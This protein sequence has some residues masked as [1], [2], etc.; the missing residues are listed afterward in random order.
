MALVLATAA[1]TGPSGVAWSAPP[2]DLPGTGS[3]GDPFRLSA[4]EDLE[5]LAAQLGA[6]NATYTGDRHYV[7]TADLDFSTRPPFPGIDQFGGT[8]DGRGHAI[9]N[10]VFTQSAT[11]S[12]DGVRGRLGLIR[13]ADGAT[14]ANLALASPVATSSSNV[15]GHYVAGIV[16]VAYNTDFRG[17][18]IQGAS[19][20][21]PGVEKVGGIVAELRG[22]TVRDSFVSGTL[23]GKKM[24][25]GIA[26]YA[27]QGNVPAV[28]ERTVVDADLTVIVNGGERGVDAAM[29]VNYPGNPSSGSLFQHNVALGGTITYAG[30]REGFAG[31]IVGYTGYD[32]WTARDNLAAS[33]ITIG[34]QTVTGPGA[35]GEQG[36]D[37][38]PEALAQQATYEALNWDF[39]EKWAWDALA[40]H[41]VPAYVYSLFG[42]GTGEDPYQ[43]ASEYDLEFLAAELAAGNTKYTGAKSFAMT[44]DLDFAGREP[45]GGIDTFTG[46]LDGRGHSISGLVYT[47]SP[48][49]TDATK[50]GRLALI[51][52]TTGATISNLT[53]QAP[54]AVNAST[55]EGHFTAGIVAVAYRTTFSRIAVIDALF[56][57]PGAEKAAGIVAEL[58]GGTISDCF[59]SGTIVGKKLVAA[60]AAYAIQADGV[61]ARIERTLTDADLTVVSDG[62]VNGSRGI[63][64]AMVLSYPGNP[65]AGNT[66]TGNVAL[67]GSI[68]Y[69]GKV[70]GFTGR[71]IGYTDYAGWTVQNNL[72]NSAITISGAPVTGPGTKDQHGADT[73]PAALGLQAT[74]ESIGWV[75]GEQWR[76]DADLGHPMPYIVQ[77][78]ERPSRIATTIH[79]DTTSRRGFSWYSAHVSDTAAVQV[80][81]VRD[82]N[83]PQAFPA[84]RS[85]GPSGEPRYQAVATGLVPGTRYYY[86]VGFPALGLWSPTGS[87]QTA[88]GVSPFAFIDLTDTQSQSLSEAEL[89]ATTMAKALKH[90]PQAEF[91]LHQ[92]DVVEHGALEQD[93]I[94]LLDSAQ[95]TLLSTT[96]APA[97]GNHDEAAGAFIGH[98][99]LEAPNGQNTST[100]A[101]YSFDYN[102]AHIAVLNTN[103]GGAQG[104]SASQLQWLEGDVTAARAAG[105]EWVFL[106]MH[107]GLYTTATHVG[108][109]DVKAMR[110][111]VAPLI[112]RLDIDLVFQGHDHIMARSKVLNYDASGVAGAK[113]AETATITEVKNGKRIEYAIDPT[114]TIYFLPNAAGAKHYSQASGAPGGVDMEAYLE[115]FDRS[116]R[117]DQ[118]NFAA[119]TVEP[120]RVTVNCYDIR[121]QGS[122]RIFEGFGI[123]RQVGAVD[124]ALAALPAAD[125]VTPADAD[126]LTQAR[127]AVDGLTSAQRGGLEHLRRLESAER[128]WR[129]A[130]GLVAGDGSE[131]AWAYQGATGRRTVNLRN[132]TRTAFTDVP[133]RL[134]LPTT[135]QVDA[136][137]LRVFTADGVPVTHEVETWNRGGVSVVWV[138]APALP[139]RSVTTLWVYYGGDANT[140]NNPTAVWAEDYALVEHFATGG[141]PGGLVADS[142]GHATG[143][144]T[145]AALTATPS[146]DGSAGA[147]FTGSKLTYGGDLGGDFDRIAISA[148]VAVDENDLAAMSANSPYVAKESRDHGQ[149]TFWQGIAKAD[150]KLG[151]R[152]ATSSWEHSAT[153]AS[154]RFDLPLDGKSHL[155]T[156][157]Y[158]GMTYS[159]FID[160]RERHSQMVEYG[161][162][163][164][165]PSVRTTIGDY[166]TADGALASPF[167]GRIEEIQIAGVKV[168]PDFEAF[169][170]DSYFGDAVTYDPVVTKAGEPLTLIVGTP[171][172]GTEVE[173]GLVEVAGTLNRAG[174]LTATMAGD[175]VYSGEVQAGRFTAIVPVNLLGDQ[176][177]TLAV[178]SAGASAQVAVPLTVVDTVAPA[179][180]ALTVT[181]TDGGGMALS[182]TPDTQDREP[183]AVRFYATPALELGPDNLAVG[184]GSTAAR[185]PAGLTPGSGTLSDSGLPTTVGEGSN[186][187]Q[188]YRIAL[189]PE[190]VALG[191]YQV[192]WTG[193][194]DARR[195]SA[196][197][198]DNGASQ[199]RLKD[200]AADAAGAP[201]SLDVVAS[202]AEGAVSADR[203]LSVLIWRG[204]TE[205]PYG[206]GRD[207][208][209]APDPA[210]VDWG[211][212]HVPDTQLYAQATPELMVDQFEYVRDVAAERETAFVVQSGDLV[213]R[214][215]W[216]QE[217]QFRNADKAVGVLEEAGIP[218]LVSWGNH[219]Y[220]DDRNNRVLLAKYYPMSRFQDAI[221][222]TP[223]SFG[224][225]YDIDNYY[226]TSELF[227]AKLLWLTVG[228]FSADQSTDPALNWAAGVIEAHPDYTVI[229]ATHNIV[230]VGTN[231]W[232]NTIPRDRLITPYS[233][234]KLALG[235]HVTGT[236]VATTLTAGSTRAY[237]IL[238]DYQG[239]V[240]GGQEYLRHL[241]VDAE[242]GLIYS[243]VYSPLLD[244]STS[245]GAWHQTISE[246]AIPGFHGRDSENFVLELDLG[247][248]TTRTLAALGFSVAAGAPTL[249]GSAQ[250]VGSAPASVASD[251]IAAE[252]VYQW[253]AEVE[254][255]AGHVTRS[256]VITAATGSAPPAPP[257]VDFGALAEAL[258]AARALAA[259]TDSYTA[260]SLE[261]LAGAI[262]Q[263]REVVEDADS[264]QD[265]VDDALV[266]LAAAVAG[267]QAAEPVDGDGG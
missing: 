40:A 48:T 201:V 6:G 140:A 83:S 128:A 141:A 145:G 130:S 55:T 194:G 162:T 178:G 153:D 77:D 212:D 236:G 78:S 156:Q 69:T 143:A 26:S 191:E 16:V 17:I 93:W 66:Y 167:R 13:R 11:T 216:S 207:Y 81:D 107:K 250:T 10:I 238:T 239:R 242:N 183:V 41:P 65:S 266:A 185:T 170:Y 176:T 252:T 222:G 111:T 254:D 57:A 115:L 158:D 27:I 29:I 223:F 169:R 165:D 3:A 190:Q 84:T 50:R 18:A 82:F 148:I 147:T 229:L 227:G 246:A 237:G 74:Y 56:S 61:N 220:D 199:W 7:L 244:T 87:F 233:N 257:A 205:L 4:P 92:G 47:T 91:I 108:D 68:S 59:F 137:T 202:A 142:T 198:W 5:F 187:Y 181:P 166:D 267:L 20:N 2:T 241:A 211:F 70:D 224:G 155:V 150:A 98:F 123:D 218:Y 19:F 100:G 219:D 105:A 200:W 46:T 226:Y 30:N 173:S 260:E 133:V 154:H 215:Y 230:N 76:W 159:I 138:R 262:S 253:H 8:L 265:A 39:T 85:A 160:G 112:D 118:E 243:T 106:A 195:V 114:G 97:A 193:T 134:A 23:V 184:T 109:T 53:L 1:L 32:G 203:E 152:I 171:A 64:G 14:I 231:N 179:V 146:A 255:D 42:Q 36:T 99:A 248:T 33:T 261:A 192:A 63:D 131:V 204:L 175:E 51:R 214:P 245:E 119:V 72:A 259:D 235:G 90:V 15:E 75:F 25:G 12:D 139:A 247:G 209:V 249:V 136:A 117:K 62:G 126:R 164:S 234:V 120:G 80:S 110:I 125:G 21:A 251:G 228:Y 161:I 127:A 188:I 182:A 86:R 256:A 172:A 9:R 263:A 151:T 58:R 189:T 37:T 67:G 122:P 168:S 225:S 213:N 22:G 196:W 73:A 135:P 264:T 132:S 24:V 89:S 34:G 186:P 49:A 217:Y 221:D 96:L 94:D 54:E 210:D 180:P 258:D 121:S 240:Y 88:D 71:I 163:Q 103:E 45:F 208:T 174:R 79:G 95:P 124:A 28:I 113:I 149:A 44:A 102:S 35:R 52:E 144:L 129:V 101:Y 31:R 197:V 116:E 206:A 38:T 104:I 157:T 43:I 232:S 60:I 177:L